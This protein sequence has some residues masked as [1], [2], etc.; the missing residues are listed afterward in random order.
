METWEGMEE[1]ARDL[2]DQ[3]QHFQG[4]PNY[5]D[6]ADVLPGMWFALD[7]GEVLWDIFSAR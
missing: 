3:W 5:M 6:K 1:E 4:W 7:G 2:F